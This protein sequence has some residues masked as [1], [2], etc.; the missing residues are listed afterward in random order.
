MW[1]HRR[2]E[3]RRPVRPVGQGFGDG[4]TIMMFGQDRRW[5]DLVEQFGQPLPVSVPR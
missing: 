2:H 4:D 1:R 5:S 3:D